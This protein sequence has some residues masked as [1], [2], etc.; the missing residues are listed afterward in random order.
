MLA[1]GTERQIKFVGTD[2]VAS[3]PAAEGQ[4][5]IDELDEE[6]RGG[7]AAQPID[8]QISGKQFSS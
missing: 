8:Q 5:H 7:E 6:E 2:E 4:Q 1:L 3:M